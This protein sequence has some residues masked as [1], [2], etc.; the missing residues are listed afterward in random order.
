MKKLTRNEFVTLLAW[1]SAAFPASVLALA[2]FRFLVPTVVS[3]ATASVKVGRPEEFPVGRHAFLPDQ[4]LFVVATGKGVM[5]MSA[6]CTHLGCTVSRVEWG[7]QCP[8]HGSKFDS[9]GRILTGPAPVPLP[10]FR[11]FQGL[12]GQLVVDT[13]QRVASGTFFK[14]A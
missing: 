2:G 7:Y 13:G 8:C 6:A 1:A 3:G 14:V 11:V 4:R 10:W 12:D 5:A 9:D